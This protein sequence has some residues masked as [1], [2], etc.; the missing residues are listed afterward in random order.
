M[1]PPSF[2]F[3][4]DPISYFTQVSIEPGCGEGAESS[5]LRDLRRCKPLIRNNLGLAIYAFCVDNPR[6]QHAKCLEALFP[7]TR[8]ALLRSMLKSADRQWYLSELAE[9]LR[10]PPSSLQRELQSLVNAGVLK[11]QVV[12]R[13][14]YF[15]ANSGSPIFP[16]LRRIFDV[17][18]VDTTV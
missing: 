2:L 1:P 18:A 9:A 17:S 8:R 14:V 10:K 13:K 15:Q 12:G 11:R 6:M 7:A 4:A 3:P 16:S 5:D